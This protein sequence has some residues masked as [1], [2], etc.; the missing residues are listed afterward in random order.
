MK[1][2]RFLM[3]VCIL[4]M[5]CATGSGQTFA[6]FAPNETPADLAALSAV[7]GKGNPQNVKVVMSAEEAAKTPAEV[8]VLFLHQT[9]K[10]PFTGEMFPELRK[11]K[12][13][14]IGYGAGEIF[15]A[16]KLEI[17]SNACAHGFLM[18]APVLTLAED[19]LLPAAP[20]GVVKAYQ[21]EGVPDRAPRGSNDFNFA[22]HLPQADKLTKYV[23]ALA[24]WKG[25]ENYASIVR[26][27]NHIMVGIAAPATTWTADFSSLMGG[28]AANFANAPR[29]EPTPVT[30]PVTLP[31]VHEV[32]LAE[33]RN[34]KELSSVKYHFRFASPGKF[35]A[36]LEHE[37]SKSMM[38]FFSGPPGTR[39]KRV[40]AKDGEPLRIEIDISQNDI[41]KAGEAYW[42][43]KTTNFDSSHRAKGKLTINYPT[44]P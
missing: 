24:R 1:T 26:Q 4:M 7:F 9:S 37:G 18:P 22:M 44:E 10:R 6:I 21:L 36:E 27:G 2:H 16:M 32:A 28:L 35:T 3:T 25:D 23:T 17:R 39:S 12:I 13:I 43:L 29:V 5:G 31:G 41:T 40:D 33:G 15:G 8:L 42:T 34:T 11:R 38:L 14:G 30:W 19:S 20:A